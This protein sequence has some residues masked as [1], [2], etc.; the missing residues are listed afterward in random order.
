MYEKEPTGYL[1]FTNDGLVFCKATKK[2]CNEI[3]GILRD[4]DVASGQVITFPNSKLLLAQT[5][6]WH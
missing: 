4:Y 3:K 1:L 6:T 5:W 2:D